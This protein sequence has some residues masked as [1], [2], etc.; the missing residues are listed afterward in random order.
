MVSG[1]IAAAASVVVA[2]DSD[3]PDSAASDITILVVVGA[4]GAEEYG[5]KFREAAVTWA[6]GAELGG[7]RYE[8][9]GMDPGRNDDREQLEKKIADLLEEEDTGPLWIVLIGH[10]TF[11]SRTAKFN[12]RGPDF[13][14]V[15]LAEWLKEAQRP[16]AVINTTS[17]SAP[18]LKTLA[19]EDRIVITATKSAFEVFY[20]RFGEFFAKAISGLEEADL[21]NDDQVSLLEA[22]LY[23]ADQVARFY[24]MEGRLAT[25]HAL[26]DDTGDGLGTRPDW[27]EGVRATRVAK[28]D[29]TPDGERAHQFVLVP[30]AIERR[31][32]PEQRRERDSLERQLKDLVRRRQELGEEAFYDQVEPLLLQIARIYDA[33]A[34]EGE[35]SEGEASD[36]G[37]PPETAS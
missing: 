5:E 22:F 17:S 20:A 15:E 12:V 28:E 14:D 24:E 16:L 34:E 11:D 25:E 18:F 1:V 27:F 6:K 30:N 35:G 9:I 23:S 31:F 8:V 13:T 7:A 4:E 36:P 37:D 2:Q 33:V 26:I 19:G 21:D 3:E 10:G 29:A 32:S